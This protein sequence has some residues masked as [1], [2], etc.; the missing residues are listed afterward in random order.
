LPEPQ[1]SRPVASDQQAV[2][3]S[4][5]IG[6]FVL[7]AFGYS[8]M[9]FFAVD[10]WLIPKLQTSGSEGSVWLTALF[11]H[12]IAML[13]PGLAAMRIWQSRGEPM[14]AWRWSRLRYYALAMAAMLALWAL[15]AILGIGFI[16]SWRFRSPI[17]PFA[18][19]VIISGLS[20][21]WVGG[22]AEETGWCAFLLPRLTQRLGRSRAV[23]VAGAIRGLWHWPVLI[24]PLLVQVIAGEKSITILIT[25]S[26]AYGL[27]LIVSNIFFAALF[28]RVWYETESLPLLAWLHQWFDAARDISVLMIVG[29]GGSLWFSALWGVLFYPVANAALA[30]IMRTEGISYR[31]LFSRWPA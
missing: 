4:R 1:S 26:L 24:S 11:G 14:P 22:L 19:T 29:F 6:R 25:L 13:G 17:E 7:W 10:A 31:A 20:L 12:L 28:A 16:S 8:W 2:V 21:Y 27:Q 23:V 15:P 5:D 9:I 30:K 18:W 3:H